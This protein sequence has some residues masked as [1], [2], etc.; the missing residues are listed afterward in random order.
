MRI[1]IDLNK[2]EINELHTDNAIRISEHDPNNDHEVGYPEEWFSDGVA[3]ENLKD[4]LDWR[5]FS[6]N[7]TLNFSG[8]EE[9][10]TY[11]GDMS[12][13]IES[14]QNFMNDNKTT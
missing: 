5:V 8:Y 9:A 10:E 11:L 4:A 13:I 12:Y 14:V 7:D 2:V 6:F 3:W 1:F